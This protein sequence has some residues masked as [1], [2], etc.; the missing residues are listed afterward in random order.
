MTVFETLALAWLLGCAHQAVLRIRPGRTTNDLCFWAEHVHQY[1]HR[2][3][4]A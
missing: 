4:Y 3:E 2:R 1:L